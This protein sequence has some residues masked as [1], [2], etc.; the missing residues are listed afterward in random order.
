MLKIV[1]SFQWILRKCWTVIFLC[2]NYLFLKDI[3]MLKSK[4]SILSS[5]YPWFPLVSWVQSTLSIYDELSSQM[6]KTPC[7]TL[8][9]FTFNL[10]PKDSWKSRRQIFHWYW[11]MTSVEIPELWLYLWFIHFKAIFLKFALLIFFNI[12]WGNAELSFFL[13]LLWVICSRK[14][15]SMPESKYSINI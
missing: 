11:F 13:F 2:T 8:E 9:K 7:Q 15:Y 3:S 12:Y 4:Y 6:C 1:S 14:I 10:F 5:K